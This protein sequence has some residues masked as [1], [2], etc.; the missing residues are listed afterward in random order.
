M[1]SAANVSEVYV[2][3]IFRTDPDDG[4]RIYLQ[5]FRNTA[6]INSLNTPDLN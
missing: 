3:S 1:G 2:A 4:G 5:N 6:N